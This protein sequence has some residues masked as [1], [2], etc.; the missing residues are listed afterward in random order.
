MVIYPDIAANRAE[1]SPHKVAL[2]DVVSGRT[3][4][5]TGDTQWTDAL[6]PAAKGADLLI[7]EC[8]YADDRCNG[9][10]LNW[11]TL[12]TK[13]DVLGAKRTILTHLGPQ[14]L[15]QVESLGV[16]YAHDGKVVD[17]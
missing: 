5:Y 11:P 8:Y 4:T 6:I 9:Q 2:H 7:S 17:L 15:A 13:L 1:L 12:S 14:M 10:H 3:L 16:E